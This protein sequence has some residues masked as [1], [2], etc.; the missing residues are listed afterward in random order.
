MKLSLNGNTFTH[1]N[2]IPKES[3]GMNILFLVIGELLLCIVLYGNVMIPKTHGLI[4]M[5]YSP[6]YDLYHDIK[7]QQRKR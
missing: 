7:E 1:Y 4:V 2:N 6:G 3:L 5:M